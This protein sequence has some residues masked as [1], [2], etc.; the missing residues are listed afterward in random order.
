MNY[1]TGTYRTTTELITA[2]RS[3]MVTDCSLTERAFAV[4]GTGYKLLVSDANAQ[5]NFRTALNEKVVDVQD[6]NLTGL[7][8][9]FSTAY[10]ATKAWNLQT[11]YTRYLHNVGQDGYYLFDS[12]DDKIDTPFTNTDTAMTFAMW[13]KPTDFL[14][15]RY[16]FARWVDGVSPYSHNYFMLHIDGRISA[17]L[18]PGNSA[19][20]FTGRFAGSTATG[21]TFTGGTDLVVVRFQYGAGGTSVCK[22]T[23][24]NVTKDITDDDDNLAGGIRLRYTDLD[25]C[26]RYYIGC[27]GVNNSNAFKGEMRDFML[28]ENYISDDDVAKLYAKDYANMASKPVGDSTLW[29]KMNDADAGSPWTDNTL[30]SSGNGNHGTPININGATFFNPNYYSCGLFS[31]ITAGSYYFFE[32]S[33]EYAIILKDANNVYQQ[34]CFGK[35]SGTGTNTW[36]YATG[37]ISGYLANY[38][39]NN[40]YMLFSDSVLNTVY[41]GSLFMYNLTTGI[42][43]SDYDSSNKIEAPIDDVTASTMNKFLSDLWEK[44]ENQ[45]CRIPPLLK[46]Y[47]FLMSGTDR[48]YIGYSN[49]IRLINLKNTDAETEFVLGED[50]F[51]VFPLNS[52]NDTYFY[53][54]IAVKK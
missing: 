15:Q 36:I 26:K 14:S 40:K 6:G 28:F 12:T 35:L 1:K 21:F 10:D 8:M 41:Y 9:N 29:Y 25:V 47:F 27:R 3:F 17:W 30:D 13:I 32:N 39:T 5:Y 46:L 19:E 33:G 53:R 52:M 23:V 49:L 54:G 45:L 38:S 44:G 34:M 37:T 50:R 24:N 31:T 18:E 48:K 42:Q 43:Y 51:K 7:A 4:D 20:G 11:N 2:L 22:A 16:L